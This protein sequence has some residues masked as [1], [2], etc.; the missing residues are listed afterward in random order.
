MALIVDNNPNPFFVQYN[1]QDCY[2]VYW[3]D[4]LVWPDTSMLFWIKPHTTANVYFEES[5]W[6]TTSH[7][8]INKPIQYSLDGRVFVNATTRTMNVE[9][10]AYKKLYLRSPDTTSFYEIQAYSSTSKVT[11]SAKFVCNADFDIGGPLSALFNYTVSGGNPNRCHYLFM[12]SNVISANT[13]EFMSEIRNGELW[14]REY[15]HRMFYNC[16]KLRNIPKF[17]SYD[18]SGT[19]AFNSM[20]EGCT[21]L[22]QLPLLTATTIRSY[23]Y[24]YMF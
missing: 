5:Y 6:T 23:S 4:N 2:E 20:F 15:Y 14:S 9:V 12:N 18:T 19:H 7:S 16:T 8:L 3:N 13:V 21:S 17:P 22:T 11:R 10:P 1:Y 24:V